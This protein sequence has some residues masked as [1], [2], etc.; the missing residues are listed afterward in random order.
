[1]RRA[2]QSCNLAARAGCCKN[3]KVMSTRLAFITQNDTI[4]AQNGTATSTFDAEAF[5]E[6]R[7]ILF[8]TLR[9]MD[10][11]FGRRGN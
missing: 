4:A 1:M 9:I 11:K 2:K 8:W 5:Q 7:E 3:I 10:G 6:Q